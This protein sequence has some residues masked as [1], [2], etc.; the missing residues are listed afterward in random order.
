MCAEMSSRSAETTIVTSVSGDLIMIVLNYCYY[1]LLYNNQW[2]RC[3]C[4]DIIKMAMTVA[5]LL[6]D[7]HQFLVHPGWSVSLLKVICG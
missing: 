1:Y 6:K 5:I 7:E 2:L 4:D 3:A